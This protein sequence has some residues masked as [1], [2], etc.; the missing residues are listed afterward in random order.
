M[1]S[2][3]KFAKAYAISNEE[4]HML[5]LFYMSISPK[6]S[7]RLTHNHTFVQGIPDIPINRYAHFSLFHKLFKRSPNLT[8]KIQYRWACKCRASAQLAHSAQPLRPFPKEL[9]S[10]A[11]PR[12]LHPLLSSS[13]AVIGWR[14]LGY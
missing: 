10:S 3:A 1:T 11:H 13:S 8:P 5:L 4:E 7:I 6:L 9:R 14:K 12:S 2:Y